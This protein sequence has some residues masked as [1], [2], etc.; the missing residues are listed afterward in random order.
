MIEDIDIDA[1]VFYR[2][3]K[4]EKE[5]MEYIV[6]ISVIDSKQIE[7][8]DMRYVHITAPSPQMAQ[9]GALREVVNKERGKGVHCLEMGVYQLVLI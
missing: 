8:H 6:L 9:S 7:K 5:S 3:L 2:E 1:E 4:E